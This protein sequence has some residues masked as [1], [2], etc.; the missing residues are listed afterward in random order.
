MAD[1]NLSA[2][3]ALQLA[4]SSVATLKK[5]IQGA[6]N[7]IAAN[8]DADDTLNRAQKAA[9]KKVI[10]LPVKLD[11]KTANAEIDSIGDKL[12][13]VKIKVELDKKFFKENFKQEKFQEFVDN[14]GIKPKL[15]IGVEFDKD[16]QK[17]LAQL[18]LLKKAEQVVVR[19]A[20]K[21]KSA[22]EAKAE[23]EA[24]AKQRTAKRQAENDAAFNTSVG[25]F[26]NLSIA[27]SLKAE[28]KAILDFIDLINYLAAE[29][30]DLNKSLK[31]SAAQATFFQNTSKGLADTISRLGK[32]DR[33]RGIVD[34]ADR[35]QGLDGKSKANLESAVKILF[36]QISDI[37]DQEVR[38]R[39]ALLATGKSADVA[40]KEFNQLEIARQTIIELFNSFD[41]VDPSVFAT[42]LKSATREASESTGTLIRNLTN[43]LSR[44][45]DLINSLNAFKNKISATGGSD[46]SKKLITDQIKLVETLRGQNLSV[47]DIKANEAFQINYAVLKDLGYVDITLGRIRNTF[48]SLQ[49][50]AQGDL[51]GTI[52]GRITN[53]SSEAD[54]IRANAL[55][56]LKSLDASDPNRNEKVQNIRNKAIED[57]NRLI[58]R[59]EQLTKQYINL[60]NV[61]EGFKARGFTQSAQ[62]V[63]NLATEFIIA[64]RNGE[65]LDQIAQ[66]INTDLQKIDVGKGIESKV[67]NVVRQLER[68][69]ITLGREPDG[70]FTGILTKFDDL[71]KNL[72]KRLSSTTN[73]LGLDELDKMA[74]QGIFDIRQ[75]ERI[76]KFIENMSH[77]FK[78]LAGAQDDLAGAAAVD[79]W[80]NNFQQE[81]VK[82][83]SSGNSVTK[84]MNEIKVLSDN[85]FIKAK[86]AAE[87][88]L[89]GTISKAAG[90]AAKRLGA[91]L[92]LAQGLYA[93][94]AQI[95]Q[96][97][98]D[99]VVID[100]E[101]IKLEQVITGGLSGPKLE[102]AYKNLGAL[103]T[104]ILSLGT[105]MGI[106]TTEVAGA[107]Q[108]LAQ[109]GL[110]GKNLAKI[111]DVVTKS[112]LGPSFA[113][114]NETSEAAI[115]IMNQFKLTAEQTADA[116]GGVNRLSAQYAVEAG[117]ITEAVRRA[118]GVFATAGGNIGEFSAAFTVIK[119][120]TREADESIAT[121]LRNITQ[122][123]QRSSVQ[124][125]LRE[126][127][128][129][130]LINKD[131]GNFIGFSQAIRSVGEAIKKAGISENSPLFSEIRERLAGTLQAGR[132]TPLLQNYEKL[133]E[134]N[135][136][137]AEG[138]DSIE[139]DVV[140]A[141]NSIEN[142]L[143]RAKSA[144][145]ELFTELLS[146]Q[147]VK[148]LIE[149]FTQLTVVITNMLKVLNT[150]PGAILA[151]GLAFKAVTPFK[152]IVQGVLS[153]FTPRKF[154]FAKKNGGG[155]IPGSGPNKDSVLSY[156]TTGEYVIKRD[157]VDKYGVSFLDQINRGALPRNKG[158]IIPGVPSFNTGGLLEKLLSAGFKLNQTTL[159]KYVKKFEVKNFAESTKKGSA[160]PKSK[161]IQLA[162]GASL[163]VL[164]HEF[165]HIITSQLDKSELLSILQKLPSELTSSTI[166]RMG[167]T[168]SAYGKIGSDKF[169]SKFNQELSADAV[170]AL[171]KR[172]R[173]DKKYAGDQALNDLADAIERTTGVTMRSN[174]RPLAE[175][176]GNAK[177][178][179][180]S[181]VS[182]GSNTTGYRPLTDPQNIQ[183]AKSRSI[184]RGRNKSTDEYA[185][186]LLTELEDR[187]PKDQ[188]MTPRGARGLSVGSNRLFNPIIGNRVLPN[189]PRGAKTFSSG[190]NSR[191]FPMTAAGGSG[192]NP[193]SFQTAAGGGGDPPNGP[194]GGGFPNFSK[195][196]D[197]T[198]GVLKGFDLS[199]FA[200]KGA[201]AILVT[202]LLAMQA[203]VTGVNAELGNLIAAMAAGAATFTA[204]T[205]AGQIANFARTNI[206]KVTGLGKAGKIA[207]IGRI[208][209]PA[210]RKT[211]AFELGQKSIGFR[212]KLA[213][214]GK[215]TRSRID[216][217]LPFDVRRNNTGLAQQ[218]IK[219][220]VSLDSGA[221]SRTSDIIGKIR[222]AKPVGPVGVKNVGSLANGGKLLGGLA[223]NLNVIGIA[224]GV[225]TG[226]L[227]YFGSSLEQAGNAA[228]ENAK[229]EEDAV[230]ASRSGRAGKMISKGA[231]GA[232]TVG[233]FTLTG[234]AIGAAFGGAGA[235]PG[236]IAGAIL[237]F[238]ALFK[239]K[240]YKK[241]EGILGPVSA[242]IQSVQEAIGGWFNGMSDAI[243][244]FFVGAD[245]FDAEVGAAKLTG[246]QN[247][248]KNRLQKSAAKGNI[249]SNA[250]NNAELADVLSTVQ[251]SA[252]TLKGVGGD[253][254]KIDPAVL[255][256]QKAGL[257]RVSEIYNALP[258]GERAKIIDMAKRSGTDMQALFNTM[259]VSLIESK[260]RAEI[261][262][263]K[264]SLFFAGLKQSVELSNA[265]LSGVEANMEA[266]SNTDKSSFAIPNQVF[267]VIAAGFEPNKLGL[268]RFG[269]AMANLEGQVAQFDS[270][271]YKALKFQV[272][273]QRAT[274]S[275]KGAVTS[276]A[277]KN[278]KF[279]SKG[280]KGESLASVLTDSFSLASGGN[281]ELDAKFDEFVS[282]KIE[283]MGDA[284]VDDNTAATKIN[285]WLDEF[286]N[287]LNDTNA[288]ETVKRMNEINQSFTNQYSAIMKERFSK[289][290]EIVELV[291]SN[292][293]KQK[294]LFEIQNKARGLTGSKLDKAQRSQ[295][296]RL[297][298]TKLGATLSG[299]GLDAS[300]TP[301]Q[302]QAAL[303]QSQA[304]SQ[305][306]GSIAL[307]SG[308]RG[309][310]AVAAEAKIKA[311][312]E[313]RQRRLQGGLQYI[314]GGTEEAAF[315]MQQFEK[316]AQKA[317]ASSKF[318]TDSLLGTDDQI[319]ET[320]KGIAAFQAIDN[321]KSPE[322]AQALLL[323]MDEGKR[324]AL[325]SYL[326]QNEDARARFESQVGFGSGISGGKEAKAAEGQI[327]LQQ[328][329]NAA[330]AAGIADA[331]RPNLAAAEDLKK[332]YQE[333][334][335]NNM[336]AVNAANQAAQRLVG[337]I[338]KLPNVITHEVTV[339]L[340]GANQLAA[341]QEGIKGF[342]QQQINNSLASN[343]EALKA[344][345]QGLNTPT[346]VQ[347]KF[348]RTIPSGGKL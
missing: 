40:A 296:L 340:V 251:I 323:N 238:A 60:Q 292:A 325:N 191:F 194:F 258:E 198:K 86:V 140:T 82:V 275:L 5:E 298:E 57:I 243:Y 322:Q 48:A 164:A 241:F 165:G 291:K 342:V 141:F 336:A 289:E 277:I 187:G 309:T 177:V 170:T 189:G 286:S 88:G 283:S 242:F 347:E 30:D 311:V 203:S 147:A 324:T 247:F 280:N 178:A 329:A 101:F 112:Q 231:A 51:S 312:E 337:E 252:G 135:E 116:L 331:L 327:K 106:A 148:F 274:R 306:A 172:A 45:T 77:K 69:K 62:A 16:A 232:G 168:P 174:I 192:N 319:I 328:E 237:G 236:A 216:A 72:K 102:A 214:S 81:A 261:A 224:F 34:L 105:S 139:K 295:A 208:A 202:S 220:R 294:T 79:K 108:V 43:D 18:S 245:Q 143:Q 339:N 333:E 226:A 200:S 145:I 180:R 20:L 318:L 269:D 92:V 222:G 288:L 308:L 31:V 211:A 169:N 158:G 195:G 240:L 150:L 68:M 153:Q 167:R 249:S 65:S 132:I 346:P 54:A 262:F 157:S 254:D 4:K 55:A 125:Y 42:K 26:A 76:N 290:G 156:L 91:F 23:R 15:K 35:F 297:D 201:L 301:Q 330:L 183:R 152:G 233:G 307:Q 122:R 38:L 265:R 316:A 344:N 100:K 184:S 166:N 221:A 173:G 341:L 67:A 287:S 134:Y 181:S 96:S 255:E 343:N 155:I 32:G 176:G 1:F 160:N 83:I 284:F 58:N 63:S 74:T 219:D 206:G 41:A 234:A 282:P 22:A 273:G 21:K 119:E 104:Q 257:Q 264:M 335:K 127:L 209:D 302:L 70:D 107:A 321:A 163:S 133:I 161:S 326:G 138:S 285:E 281:T 293:D 128:G 49:R 197:K 218:A 332:V 75:G 130:D 246:R 162:E 299:T 111:L 300:A 103:K 87:G 317:A 235:I 276:E 137:F 268:T 37:E 266:V 159:Q 85:I 66:R 196:L 126:T 13:S 250:L 97:I 11:F 334:F 64:A 56:Q 190:S 303:L 2:E 136:K 110:Q 114:A 253:K 12:K 320:Y 27:N 260:K 73:P 28:S 14:L 115:A 225:V 227:S 123:I 215:T 188:R 53:L 93:I 223:K 120:Q 131:T 109:A 217:N 25:P 95:S 149:G 315:A 39:R 305:N 199:I 59:S 263:E 144:V 94:Q 338:S 271:L 80:A 142:K 52:G 267:D 205:K 29:S 230:K 118:G 71:E 61:E 33:N 175:P 36:R 98:S 78:M 151:I 50:K 182:S 121:A 90:L 84:K 207:T 212:Q 89:L 99:A 10:T 3:I 7:N 6:F 229:N 44:Y 256:Q 24:D 345:N 179:K 17:A 313:E 9:Y 239:N 314:A 279:D 8:I 310:D 304:R 272:E 117:G 244:K 129:V 113:S 204:A 213:A 278:I 348:T 124:K 259:E 228:L 185:Y 270:G 248:T 193:V 171:S 46:Q 146:N 47:R 154:D 19:D 210:A 186:R